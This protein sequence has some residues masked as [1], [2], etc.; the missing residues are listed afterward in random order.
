[1]IKEDIKRRKNILKLFKSD[2]RTEAVFITEII[3]DYKAYS[4]AVYMDVALNENFIIFLV[5]I[6][7]FPHRYELFKATIS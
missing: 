2:Y 1:M 6:L 3:I 5:K 7:Y 4:P